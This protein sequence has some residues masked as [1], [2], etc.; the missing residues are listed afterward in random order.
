MNGR[1][2]QTEGARRY[3]AGDLGG[4]IEALGLAAEAEPDEPDYLR[5]LAELERERGSFP[6]A[7]AWMRKAHTATFKSA[8]SATVARLNLLAAGW[9]DLGRRNEALET[10]AVA[11][12]AQDN[13]ASRQLFA[14][15]LRRAVQAAPRHRDLAARA[16]DEA[17]ASADVLQGPATALLL[18]AWPVGLEALAEDAL[19][20]ALL[21]SGPIRDLEVERRLTALRR[22]LLFAPEDEA[23]WPLRAGLAIQGHINEYAW[24]S[25]PD[26]E[27]EIEAL[28][29]GEPTPDRL[30]KVAGYVSLGAFPNADALARRSWPAPLQ[31]V[32]RQQVEEPARQR[33][34]GE[35]AATLAPVRS[36]VS[37]K[38]R[39]QYEHNPYP[40]WVKGV[41]Q[42][43]API[44]R[45]L[46]NAFPRQRIDAIPGAEAPRILVA[47][48]GTGQHAL[49]VAARYDGARVLAID[50]SRA[51]LGY[52]ML[53]T[54]QM[55]VRNIDYGHGDILELKAHAFDAIESVG[56]LPCT[57]DPFEGVRA[58]AAM[59][60]PGGVMKLG[61]YS[62]AARLP[63]QAARRL[64]RDYPATPGGIRAFRRR[65]M[66]AAADD[67]VRGAIG[68]GDF[69]AASDCRDLLLHV[70]EH[71]HTV[72]DLR[73]MVEDNGLRL[74]GFVLPPEEMAH[75]RRANPDD[76]T[77]TDWTRWAAFE[78]ERPDTFR[79]MY[80]FWVQKGL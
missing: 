45:V 51:S 23:L 59:L 75:Y 22:E 5:N 7:V 19:V 33:L 44:Q 34:L 15:A 43:S 16:L 37:R 64:G 50:I 80:Q 63:L 13:T 68:S 42:H 71:T 18:A 41:A 52:A 69:Y 48:C 3:R 76:P 40:R 78:A 9:L 10:A 27:A 70:Q 72:P 61:L 67:P 66:E 1:E 24:V 65:I 4:A 26:E 77:A 38:V 53:R 35:A 39:D 20:V 79:R 54:E 28:M 32:L 58:L 30:L 29:G 60:R 36:A 49:A 17:W 11:V 8:K 25:E 31:G 56:M 2:W 55:G 12:R 47:G 6:A 57:E 73:R 14:E 21:T 74:I 62:T 46:Q